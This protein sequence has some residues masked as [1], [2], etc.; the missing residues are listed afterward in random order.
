MTPNDD[1]DAFSAHTKLVVFGV[2]QIEF[3]NVGCAVSRE[4][5]VWAITKA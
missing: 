3:T 2:I 1:D 4:A 5:S